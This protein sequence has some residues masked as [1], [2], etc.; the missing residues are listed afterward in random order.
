MEEQLTKAGITDGVRNSLFYRNHSLGVTEDDFAQ[1]VVLTGGF[2][3]STALRDKLSQRLRRIN[4]RNIKS[5]MASS[6]E[7]VT[8][9][10]E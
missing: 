7:L 9:E 8:P 4:V 6:L 1:K 2:G 3:E 10:L 5:G